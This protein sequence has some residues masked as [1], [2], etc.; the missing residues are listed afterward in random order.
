M[1]RPYGRVKN[2]PS[3]AIN[4]HQIKKIVPK[5]PQNNGDPFSEYQNMFIKGK[6]LFSK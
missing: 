6:Y 3:N 1:I 2:K 5:N 4:N